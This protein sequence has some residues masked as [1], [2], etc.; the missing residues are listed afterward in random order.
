MCGKLRPVPIERCHE[1]IC[2]SVHHKLAPVFEDAIDIALFLGINYIWIDYYCIDQ[3][4][5]EVKSRQLGQMDQI[6]S[7]ARITIV[8]ACYSNYQAG[9]VPTFKP[10]DWLNKWEG[11]DSDD[12]DARDEDEHN[13]E[14]LE[15]LKIIEI[16]KWNTRA[17]T[18]QEAYLSTRML[19]VHPRGMYFECGTASNA[20]VQRTVRQSV[21]REPIEAANSYFT[22]TCIRSGPSVRGYLTQ[23]LASA[24]SWFTFLVEVYSRRD[25]TYHSDA[26]NAFIA[27][28]KLYDGRQASPVKGESECYAILLM[29][30]DRDSHYDLCLVQGL[31]FFVVRAEHDDESDVFVRL[32][33]SA[34]CWQHAQDQPLPT[35][36]QK[37]KVKAIERRSEFPSWSWTGWTGAICWTLPENDDGHTSDG[38]LF[39]C[40]RRLYFTSSRPIPASSYDDGAIRSRYNLKAAKDLVCPR[41]VLETILFEADAF[42][43]VKKRRATEK[44]KETCINQLNELPAI[45]VRRARYT[46]PLARPSAGCRD[47]L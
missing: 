12:E 3:E 1:R 14:L 17:W 19:V 5:S 22:K 15:V 11:E 21:I 16:S 8:A 18:F 41:L 42:Q 9:L 32:K 44:W 28:L 2:R 45:M 6:Y 30:F 23:D 10:C 40:F 25:L 39:F 4:H 46:F 20:A 37:S 13:K 36:K 31:P 24:L 27:V 43:L 26:I 33:A 29:Q 35:P 7:N 34:L 38:E 47:S